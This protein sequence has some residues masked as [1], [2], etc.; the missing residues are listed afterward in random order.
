MATQTMNV[1]QILCADPMHGAV[2][3]MLFNGGSWFEADQMHWRVIQQRAI[4]GLQEVVKSKPTK[5][6]QQKAQV[7]LDELKDTTVQLLPQE[8]SMRVFLRADQVVKTWAP[9]AKQP[10]KTQ[11]PRNAFAL[12][13]TD[14]DE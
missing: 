7:L 9:A 12:L 6:N 11:G 4:V 5:S 1:K 13:D 14:E 8:D 10:V 2:Y 3:R